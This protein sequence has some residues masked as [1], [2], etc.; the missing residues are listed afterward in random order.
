MISIKSTIVLLVLVLLSIHFSCTSG[1]KVFEQNPP[2]T[3]KEATFQK[4]FA[5]AQ[6]FGSGIHVFLEIGNLS[7]DV[8]PDSIYFRGMA[9][10]LQKDAANPSKY[11][12]NLKT[13]AKQ[14]VIMDENPV[15]EMNNPIPD[16]QKFFPFE[17]SPNE[18]V[19]AYS[20]NNKRYYY[21]IL[22][23]KEIEALNYPSSNKGDN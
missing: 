14:D 5:G 13:S 7:Q 20:R 8:K 21:K 11:E 16:I 15:K 18:A 22:D 2:F 23:L 10:V 4:W 9:A 6:E 19:L 12:G 1:T 17:L 3:I